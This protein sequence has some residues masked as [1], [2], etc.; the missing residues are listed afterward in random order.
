MI[1]FQCSPYKRVQNK[2]NAFQLLFCLSR[3][4]TLVVFPTDFW[5]RCLLSQMQDCSVPSGLSSSQ[6]NCLADSHLEILDIALLNPA[7][8]YRDLR[9]F[10]SVCRCT[11]LVLFRYFLN[12]SNSF[13]V[14]D[15]FDQS[16]QEKKQSSIW[17]IFWLQTSCFPRKQRF[18]WPF[19]SSIS[20]LYLMLQMSLP[21]LTDS[22]ASSPI[23]LTE[24]C[25]IVI[26]KEEEE[27]AM[28]EVLCLFCIAPS[29]SVACLY[30]YI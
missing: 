26:R 21:N 2:I 9:Y 28:I 6:T 25:V 3:K 30:S 29:H 1:V 20:P 12:S 4:V 19:Q 17:K 27:G 23:L 10:S 8:G 22:L 11:L 7:S 13:P 16:T 24:V 14:W 18:L 5:I 15:I